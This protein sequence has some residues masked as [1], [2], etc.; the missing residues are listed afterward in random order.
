MNNSKSHTSH[1]LK[2]DHHEDHLLPPPPRER[3][4]EGPACPHQNDHDEEQNDANGVEDEK[5][6]VPTARYATD[7]DDVHV[8]CRE[9]KGES[10]HEEQQGYEEVNPV[11]I[12]LGDVAEIEPEGEEGEISDGEKEEDGRKVSLAE[13]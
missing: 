8:N 13:G 2:R 5:E 9:E 4:E 12:M 6:D 11:K 1:N 3:V 7:L 10:L